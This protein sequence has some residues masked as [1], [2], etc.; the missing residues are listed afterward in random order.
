MGKFDRF[1]R[2]TQKDDRA[3]DN[4]VWNICWDGKYDSGFRG[5]KQIG[6][7]ADLIE[8]LKTRDPDGDAE[9]VLC[10]SDMKNQN[11]TMSVTDDKWF[12]YFFPEDEAVCGFQSLGEDRGDDGT[13]SMP[14]GSNIEV[15]NYTLVT[16][17]VAFK[18]AREFMTT[19]EMPLCVDWDEL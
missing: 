16:G 17:E 2:K 3:A 4:A 12:L 6:D 15:C 8:I 7:V 9:F 1:L 14:A 10:R 11:L 19:G 5:N 13:T 18:A